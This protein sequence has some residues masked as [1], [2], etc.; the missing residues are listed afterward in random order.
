[1][2]IFHWAPSPHADVCSSDRKK[3]ASSETP[4]EFTAGL[5][6]VPIAVHVAT[7]PPADVANGVGR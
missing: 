3:T 4:T 6:L 7:D 1:M 5:L 2:R